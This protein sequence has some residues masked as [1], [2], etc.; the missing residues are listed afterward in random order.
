MLPAK[1]SEFF[2]KIFSIYNRNLIKR[3]FMSL[4]IDGFENL[5]DRDKSIPHIIY[6][7]H[8]S[9]WDGLIMFQICREANVDLFAMMEEKQVLEYPFHR[10]LGAFSVVRENPRDALKAVKY[11]ADLL[12][13]DSERCVLIFPQGELVANDK[14][15]IVFFNGISRVIEKVENTKV[16]PTAIR[17]ECGNDWKPEIFVKIGEPEKFEI[18]R[19]RTELTKT[20][21]TKLTENLDSIAKS[22]GDKNLESF[23]KII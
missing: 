17:Y 20:L 2:Q 8:S 19:N 12:R 6:A 11:A 18:S 1:K 3:R 10:K 15:P 22:V 23:K 21:E 14:R 7:N 9:W 16:I 4:R 5:A 13:E